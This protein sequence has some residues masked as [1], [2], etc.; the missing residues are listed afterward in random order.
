ML[1]DDLMPTFEFGDV[2][3]TDVKAA[4]DAVF[5]AV[6]TFDMAESTTIRWLF[7]MRGIPTS[8]LTLKDFEKANLKVLAEKPNE[9]IVLGLAGEF[10]SLTSGLRDLPPDKF[11]AFNDAGFIKACW[12][13]AVTE[14]GNNKS[15]VTTEI[16]IIGTDAASVA[17]VKNVWG[18]VKPPTAMISKEILKLIKNQA[19]REAKGK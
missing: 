6:K 2:Q 15:R 3:K 11:R 10:K 13:F 9:E 19:E 12:N 8:N 5:R 17:K 16:R 18:L 4:S 7:K 14:I 1:I